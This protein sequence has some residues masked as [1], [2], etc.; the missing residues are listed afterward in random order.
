MKETIYI[1][2][3]TNERSA[4]FGGTLFH[5]KNLNTGIRGSFSEFLFK[6]Y[7]EKFNMIFEMDD[8]RNHMTI[9]EQIYE[10]T[11]R[12]KWFIDGYFVHCIPA[13]M[14]PNLSTERIVVLYNVDMEYFRPKNKL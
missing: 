2:S 3:K 14:W 8:A 10:A 6:F 4:T 1:S 12:M 7:E 9:D 13:H 5:F 11:Q